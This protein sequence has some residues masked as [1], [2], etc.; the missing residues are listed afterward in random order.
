MLQNNAPTECISNF[1]WMVIRLLIY[2]L[3]KSTIYSNLQFIQKLCSTLR[4]RPSGQFEHLKY[5]FWNGQKVFQESWKGYLGKINVS[6][7][8]ITDHVLSIPESPRDPNLGSWSDWWQLHNLGEILA[9][10]VWLP[11]LQEHSWYSQ[12]RWNHNHKDVGVGAQTYTPP[13]QHTHL[14]P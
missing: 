6:R 11:T 5:L 13:P 3:F 1:R 10:Q 14:P 12:P 4:W 7:Q 9:V 8:R 2:N